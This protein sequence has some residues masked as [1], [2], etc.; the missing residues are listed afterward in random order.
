MVATRRARMQPETPALAA[1][2]CTRPVRAATVRACPERS[3]GVAGAFPITGVQSTTVC[4]CGYFLLMRV[5]GGVFGRFFGGRRSRRLG[6]TRLPE[7]P[8]VKLGKRGLALFCSFLRK[9]VVFCG[10]F[11][12]RCCAL[13]VRVISAPFFRRFFRAVGT[14]IAQ[15]STQR[16]RRTQREDWGTASDKQQMTMTQNER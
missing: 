3:R 1:T 7:A 4:I 10:I 15:P 2:L 16:T 14:R 11:D 8:N 13:V 5:L 9:S 6:G 12:R